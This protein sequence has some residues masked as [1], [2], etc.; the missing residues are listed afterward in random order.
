MPRFDILQICRKLLAYIKFAQTKTPMVV[1]KPRHGAEYNWNRH[2]FKA[3]P[4]W[5]RAA[6]FI[7]EEHILCTL[8]AF[9]L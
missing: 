8:L 5:N 6:G 9:K 1:F 7:H 4:K 2:M 3:L